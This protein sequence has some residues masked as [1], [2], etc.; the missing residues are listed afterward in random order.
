M[1]HKVAQVMRKLSISLQIVDS[2]THLQLHLLGLGLG[3]HQFEKR[4]LLGIFQLLSAVISIRFD[5]LTCL[6]P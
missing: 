2:P 3:M 6:C 5:L 4:A 1:L